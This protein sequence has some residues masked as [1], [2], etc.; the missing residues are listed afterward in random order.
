MYWYVDYIENVY[1]GGI[2]NTTDEEDE[3]G[4]SGG[5][6]CKEC[7]KGDDDEKVKV[8]EEKDE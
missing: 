3:D 6:C 5:E 7:A 4:S 8:K 2:Y 1:H